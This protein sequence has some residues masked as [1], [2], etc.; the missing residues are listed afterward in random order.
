MKLFCPACGH[1]LKVTQIQAEPVTDRSR[2]G[3]TIGICF[4]CQLVYHSETVYDKTPFMALARL[5]RITYPTNLKITLAVYEDLLAMIEPM[6][7]WTIM[8]KS[9]NVAEKCKHKIVSLYV[10]LYMLRD[11]IKE[12]RDNLKKANP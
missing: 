8:V 2:L 6:I 10:Y 12:F 3:M 5:R 4:N 1:T 11:A 7:Q 9:Q